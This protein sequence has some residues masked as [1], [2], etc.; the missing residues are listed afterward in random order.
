MM[1]RYRCVTLLAAIAVLCATWSTVHA[2]ERRFGVC[3]DTTACENYAVSYLTFSVKPGW[4]IGAGSEQCRM[5]IIGVNILGGRAAKLRGIEVSAGGN[6]Q[7]VDAVGIQAAGIG[8]IVA[9]PMAGMQVAGIGN[10]AGGPSRGLQ[11]AGFGNVTAG[12]HAG[13]QVSAFG[14]VAAE[15]GRGLQVAGFG[16]VVNGNNMGAQVAVFGNVVS[17]HMRGVQFAIFGNVAAEG[18]TGIQ[19][20]AFGNVSVG[21]GRAMQAAVF[22]NVAA[23]GAQ[24]IQFANFGNVHVGA[25][26][27]LQ[28]ATF[29]NIAGDL[30][31]LQFGMMNR[32]ANMPDT[33]GDFVGT[34]MELV[35]TGTMHGAQV[36]IYNRADVATGLQLGI[37]NRTK[38]HSGVPIGVVS[39]VDNV[40]F[41][42][43]IEASEI[44]IVTAEMRSGTE[45]FRSFLVIGASP[46]EDPFVFSI[47]YGF[48]PRVYLESIP[49]FLD[50]NLMGHRVVE[51]FDWGSPHILTSVRARLGWRITPSVAITAA[52]SLNLSVSERND[53]PHLAP[54]TVR[55]WDSDDWHY[56]GWPGVSIGLEF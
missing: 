25:P 2:E 29:G 56:R 7:C 41:R 42:W 31:G 6:V 47:G 34:D 40:P 46:I 16:N 48:G 30:R 17:E 49:A 54:S 39:I 22:G 11:I 52:A 44:G 45:T 13:A 5:N 27:R 14:N 43:G 20:A 37:V 26:A 33:I 36:G 51:D 24:A 38:Q 28:I 3:G 10:I 4:S 32:V 53:G 9:G 18:A 21:S 1:N 50:F 55:S 15:G 19:T 8:N 12:H 35:D 23:D